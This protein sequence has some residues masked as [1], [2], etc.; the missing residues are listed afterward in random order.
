MPKYF[1]SAHVFIFKHRKTQPNKI[2]AQMPKAWHARA[3]LLKLFALDILCNSRK[4]ALVRLRGTAAPYPQAPFQTDGRVRV[5]PATASLSRWA[6][7]TPLLAVDW[8]EHAPTNS[9]VRQ[10][11]HGQSRNTTCASQSIAVPNPQTTACEDEYEPEFLPG[12]DRA[13]DWP[14]DD[15]G[16]DEHLYHPYDD[17]WERRAGPTG[18]E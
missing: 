5:S 8:S 10:G 6:A 3:L 18:L 14:D 16:F 7:C 12:I 17:E 1:F 2:V 9:A 4:L 13:D 11:E 15:D